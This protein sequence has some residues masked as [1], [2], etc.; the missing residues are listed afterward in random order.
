MSRASFD[1]WICCCNTYSKFDHEGVHNAAH[2]CHKVE[3][4]PVVLEVTL[5]REN[6]CIIV[7]ILSIAMVICKS[8]LFY[9]C[10]NC[11]S[12]WPL[13]FF[14]LYLTLYVLLYTTIYQCVIFKCFMQMRGCVEK[15]ANM[16][17]RL[18]KS[19]YISWTLSVDC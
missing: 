7:V 1:D 2:H 16:F 6:I 14:K 5:E 11:I 12:E 9:E 19:M 13:H 8:N 15:N 3:S 18:R 17:S 4:V 10:M